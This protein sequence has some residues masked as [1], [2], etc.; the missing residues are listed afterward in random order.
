M[1]PRGRLMELKNLLATLASLTLLA[2]APNRAL[3]QHE[4]FAE[5]HYGLGNV[6]ADMVVNVECHRRLRDEAPR[7]L[8]ALIELAADLRK[9]TRRDGNRSLE[10]AV[11]TPRNFD[12]VGCG[13]R[14]GSCQRD[15][16]ESRD[17]GAWECGGWHI[18]DR[19]ER[20]RAQW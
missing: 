12:Q 16:D 18:G 7:N 14:V 9:P 13:H 8:L 1:T 15:P 11:R 3:A 5:A 2:A 17:R 19:D 20:A 6:L 4:R 10:P